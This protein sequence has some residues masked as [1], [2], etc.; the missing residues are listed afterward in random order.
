LNKAKDVVLGYP[1]AHASPLESGNID[2]V[3]F[4]NS[5]NQW[6]RLSATQFFRS[7]RSIAAIL[8]RRTFHS[9]WLCITVLH[10][11][12]RFLRLLRP[13]RRRRLLGWLSFCA[14]CRR[15]FDLR[16]LWRSRS[17]LCRRLF[18]RRCDC[19]RS[20]RGNFSLCGRGGAAVKHCDRSV[21]FNS[22][23]FL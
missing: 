12:R 19:W 11:F 8:S 10:F 14:S 15:R 22:V 20:L 9:G 7:R 2:T 18:C 4:R 3:L 17:W 6:T 13:A 1:A 16:L 23:A 21:Y 5:P